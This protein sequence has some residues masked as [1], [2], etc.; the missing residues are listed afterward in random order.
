M[1]HFDPLVAV[2][3]MTGLP[4]G[5]SGT[6]LAAGM[7]ADA[8]RT[9][10]NAWTIAGPP[11][12]V[13]PVKVAALL[14]LDQ[15]Y[16]KIEAFAATAATGVPTHDAALAAAQ[17]L[18]IWLEKQQDVIIMMSDPAVYA[19]VQAMGN[20]IVAQE[21]ATP[22]TTG[23]TQSVLD[24]LL[25]LAATTVPWWQSVGLTSAVSA[26]DCVVAGLS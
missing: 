13:P 26:D 17:T 1:G 3:T 20:A 9:A 12:D 11:R 6:P 25:A 5:V 7:T 2:W 16:Q 8:K 24:A 14:L 15:T 22:G 21:T 23:F 4:A 18:M 19:V 10:V